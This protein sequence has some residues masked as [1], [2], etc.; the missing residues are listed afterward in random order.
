MKLVDI[1]KIYL[2][3]KTQNVIDIKSLTAMEYLDFEGKYKDYQE[4]H[5]FWEMCYVERGSI[6]LFLNGEE[7]SI[8]E[9]EMIII[10]PDKTHSYY[11]EK[12][13]LS[14]AFVVCFECFSQPLKSLS[15]VLIKLQDEFKECINKIVSEYK[16]TFFMN[17]DD[18][19]EELEV[20]SF[21]GQQIIILQLEYM[22]ICLIRNLTENKNHKVVFLSEERFYQDLVDIVI[23]Y[24]NKNI[25]R[26][27]SI[28][29]ICRK[30][31]YSSSFLCKTFKE[32][33]GET[34]LGY[35]NKLKMEEAKRLLKE[36]DLSLSAISARLGFSD[37]KYFG[38]MFKRIEKMP[39]SVYRE[40]E[41]VK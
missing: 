24:F 37:A 7:K 12:G 21:G 39:P 29:E 4:S 19:L 14:K 3:H 16:N 5:N 27:I 35:F 36:T 1:M 33:T 9:G 2:K 32:Q 13:N 15:G 20:S 38:A 26:N 28:K 8:S 10:P 17:E 31:N 18:V 22:F 40:K 11:S 25:E 6:T 30:V 23:D 41:N 34:L